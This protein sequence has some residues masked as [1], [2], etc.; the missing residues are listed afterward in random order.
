M[1]AGSVRLRAT[2][3]PDTFSI[4]GTGTAVAAVFGK[5]SKRELQQGPGLNYTAKAPVGLVLS[6]GLAV[7]GKSMP[8]RPAVK[9][10]P[11]RRPFDIIE[12][13]KAPAPTGLFSTAMAREGISIGSAPLVLERKGNVA[14]LVSPAAGTELAQASSAKGQ[15][16]IK[17]T[18]APKTLALAGP[19]AAAADESGRIAI[20]SLP[21]GELAVVPLSAVLGTQSVNTGLAQ[22]LADGLLTQGMACIRWNQGLGTTATTVTDVQRP[23]HAVVVHDLHG[24]IRTEYYDDAWRLLRT[25]TAR[26]AR[27]SI[28]TFAMARCTA[29]ATPRAHAH[30][31]RPTTMA[32]RSA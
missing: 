6:K 10:S 14:T 11:C 25:S 30:A 4:E 17:A 7:A 21:G 23:E 12:P 24:V 32:S 19:V 18:G 5:D 20:V 22:Q 15:I 27:P 29:C 16:T 31:S 13:R 2:A 3:A 28:T 26:P 9:K 1:K 8:P